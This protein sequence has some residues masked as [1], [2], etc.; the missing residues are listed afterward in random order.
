VKRIAVIVLAFI[1]LA[2][3]TW[4]VSVLLQRQDETDY[5]LRAWHSLDRKNNRQSQGVSSPWEDIRHQIFGPKN[6]YA[7]QK[8]HEA[9]LV[10]S[11][12]LTN[13]ELRLTNQIMTREMRSNF[14]QRIRAE[15]GTNQDQLWIGYP[16]TSNAGLIPL[17]PAKDVPVWERIF[18]ESAARYASNV[19]S[20]ALTGPARP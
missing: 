19:S 6:I 16:L 3:I 10:Q 14:Y 9:A 2:I 18:R 20:P 1:G 12:Y 7:A 11:G 5:H 13:I 4:F 17:V 15:L 8:A